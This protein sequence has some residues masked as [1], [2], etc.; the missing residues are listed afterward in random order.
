MLPHQRPSWRGPAMV[1]DGDLRQPCQEVGDADEAAGIWLTINVHPGAR[2]LH[3][4]TTSTGQ[5]SA[6]GLHWNPSL[7]VHGQYTLSSD[8]SVETFEPNQRPA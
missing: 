6:S 4:S 8:R 3:R 1:L 5:D 7:T 2:Q